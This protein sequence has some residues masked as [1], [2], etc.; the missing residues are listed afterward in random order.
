ML[1]SRRALGCVLLAFFMLAASGC[2]YGKFGNVPK[3]I[4]YDEAALTAE[5]EGRSGEAILDTLGDPDAVLTDGE[6]EYWRYRNDKGFFFNYYISFGT[7]DVRDLI[8]TL[9]ND[10]VTDVAL[11]KYGSGLGIFSPAASVAN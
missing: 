8:L 11:L 9:E 2:A 5:F 6:M 10:R 3:D 1:I 4:L 7:T